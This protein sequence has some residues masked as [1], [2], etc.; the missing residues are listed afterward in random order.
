MVRF[1]RDHAGRPGSTGRLAFYH[2]VT[3]SETPIQAGTPGG[4]GARGTSILFVARTPS[5][6]VV[7]GG[8]VSLCRSGRSP[9]VPG[10][11]AGRQCG[12]GRAERLGR[13]TRPQQRGEAARSAQSWAH[14]KTWPQ[15][16]QSRAA[17]SGDTAATE[18]RSRGLSGRHGRNRAEESRPF[19]KTRPQ[20][21]LKTRPQRR[22]GR[23]QR[24]LVRCPSGFLSRCGVAR[25]L[26]RRRAARARA[27]RWR[28]GLP[29]RP[30]PPGSP[31]G[32]CSAPR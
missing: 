11:D 18:Q 20:Q 6:G 13:E 9:T 32:C 4:I 17:R 2:V 30:R 19:G 28:R 8:S 10:R 27:G 1:L 24:G 22:R 12:L 21:K 26:A 15:R 31:G 29:A 16:R 7:T 23:P 3:L 25:P 5:I 14:G